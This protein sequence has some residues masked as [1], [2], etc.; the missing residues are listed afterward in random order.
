MDYVLQMMD[1]GNKIDGLCAKND[2]LCVENDGFCTKMMNFALRMMNS[3]LQM[4]QMETLK[5]FFKVKSHEDLAAL[6]QAVIY[7]QPLPMISYKKLFEETRDGDQGKFAETLRD[8][9]ILN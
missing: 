1:F 4:L 9:V 6:Q 3:V 2:E 5:G 7:D 8:Q